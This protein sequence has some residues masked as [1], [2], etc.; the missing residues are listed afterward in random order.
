LWVV[1]LRGPAAIIGFCGLRVRSNTPDPEL[2]YALAPL[3]WGRGFATEA[4]RAV[5]GYAFEVLGLERV[6]AATDAPNLASER[7][8]QRVGMRFS[9]RETVEGRETVFYVITRSA[10]TR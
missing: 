7:V 4:G 5:L 6:S 3:Y 10:L 1:R 9:H 8:L 2:L